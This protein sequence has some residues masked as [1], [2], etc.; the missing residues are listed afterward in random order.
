MSASFYDSPHSLAEAPDPTAHPGSMALLVVEDDAAMRQMC[1]DLFARRGWLAEGAEHAAQA[2]ARIRDGLAGRKPAI[3]I[4]LSDVRLGR[5]TNGMDLLR[6]VKALAPEVPVL[7]MTGYATVQDAVEAM[8]R[9]AADYV[10]KPFER[11]E[12]IAKVEAHAP[13]EPAAAREGDGESARVGMI[14]QSPIMRALYRRIEAAARSAATVMITGESGTGK[15]LVARAIHALGERGERAFIPVNCAAL[16]ENLIESELFGHEAGSFTGATRESKGLFRAADGGTI[17]LDEVVDMPKDTQAKL[18]RVLQDRRVRPVGSTRE[19]PVDVRVIAATNWDIDQA[20]ARGVL[21]DDLYYRLGVV[22]MHLP[23]LRDRIEDLPIL[24]DHFLA[25]HGKR[26]GRR[27]RRVAPE[28]LAQ[29]SRYPWPGNVR[30][31]ES[32]VESSYALGADEQLMPADLPDWLRCPNAGGTP[33]PCAEGLAPA[34]ALAAASPTPLS[35]NDME[36]EAL[37]RALALSQGNKSKAAQLLGVSRKR[38]YRML[39]D[40]GMPTGGDDPSDEP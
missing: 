18:L 30:E 27:I 20:R 6:E 28:T 7:L 5:E 29:L 10:T 16:P 34:P 24:L 12:L 15:E 9:G 38:L 2:L 39:N 3:Q 22:R 35:M 1:C 8:K 13:G 37:N 31:L 32:V 33:A 4:V 11:A 23:P 19:L 26:N 21:R 40:Y 36:R 14:G 25:K 17:F